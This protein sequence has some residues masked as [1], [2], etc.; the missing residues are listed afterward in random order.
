MTFLLIVI[1]SPFLAAALAPWAMRR[2]PA[3]APHGFAALAA[4]LA[5][6]LLL[7]LPRVLGGDPIVIDRAWLAQ[8]HIR[9]SIRLD[10]FAL[11]MSALVS[12]IGAVVLHYSATYMAGHRSRDRFYLYLLSF[13][14]AMLGIILADNLFLL[15]I[16]WELTSVTSFLLIGIDHEREA[17][18]EAALRALLL[19]GAGSLAMLGGFVL[20]AEAAGTGS[21]GGLAGAAKL[22]RESPHYE[23]I[24]VLVFLGAFT[25]SAQFPFHFWLPGAMEAPS[26]ISAYL[27]SATMVKAG[28]YLLA[29][30]SPVLGGTALWHDTLLAT[31][32]IT[33]VLGA[34]MGFAQRDMKKMLAYTTVSV[35]GLLVALIGVGTSAAFKALIVFWT[36][37]AFYKATLFLL[38][39]AI[40]HEFGT[41]DLFKLKGLRRQAPLLM[42][43]GGL[44]ALSMWGFPPFLGFLGK[45]LFYEVMLHEPGPRGLAPVVAGGIAFAAMALMGAAGLLAGFRPFLGKSD[46]SD[47]THSAAGEDG[48]GHHDSHILGLGLGPLLLAAGGLALGVFPGAISTFLVTSAGDAY[49]APISGYLSLWHGVT[50]TLMLSGATLLAALGLVWLWPRTQG[51]LARGFEA[52]GLVG[53]LRLYDAMWSSLKSLTDLQTKVLA[54]VFLR[55]EVMIAIAT[56]PIMIG[57]TMWISPGEAVGEIRISPVGLHEIVLAVLVL[58]SALV[59]IHARSLPGAIAGL[60]GAG[61][62]VA[63][64][65]ARFGGPDL[66]MTQFAVE[67]LT[68]ILFVLVIYRLPKPER[69]TRLP[70][71]ITSALVAGLFGGVI[72]MLTFFSS[73]SAGESRISGEFVARSLPEAKGRNIVNVILVDFRALDTLGEITVLATAALGIYTLMKLRPGK[74]TGP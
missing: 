54:R 40:D 1:F 26:P 55:H 68:V 2:W 61:Y 58:L 36:A 73:L 34:T 62:G 48:A 39:G 32:M 44:A 5:V 51:A 25:K 53:P 42:A 10:A 20:L 29:R 35:L 11:L 72:A 46:A 3:W 28:V 52:M 4:A 56:L 47:A 13:M 22:L 49:G 64:V 6:G 33:M 41:R 63:L 23:E 7:M 37:H 45:E 18:R 30:L 50:P 24:V 38:T 14:G 65:F 71:R 17:A 74:D 9:F 59:A 67:T 19:T 15:F 60:G 12:G 43:V 66:A 8:F 27:H 31:G 21:I 69:Y 57:L 70:D 16:F